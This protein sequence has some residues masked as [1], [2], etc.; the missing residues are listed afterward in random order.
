[1]PSVSTGQ[2]FQSSSSQAG[3]VLYVQNF[4]SNPVSISSVYVQNEATGLLVG[5]LE[6]ANSVVVEPGSVQQIGVDFTPI[7][8]LAYEFTVVT[9]LGTQATTIG[10]A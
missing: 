9:L 8:G 7:H 4:G 2:V 1:M 10:I 6:I 5:N 3:A